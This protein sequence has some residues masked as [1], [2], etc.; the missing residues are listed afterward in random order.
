MRNSWLKNY[1]EDEK[2]AS[3]VPWNPSKEAIKEAIKE[4]KELIRDGKT[5]SAI[6]RIRK[7]I[8]C[9]LREVKEIVNTLKGEVNEEGSMRHSPP[10]AVHNQVDEYKVSCID[11]VGIE[12]LF[13]VGCVYVAMRHSELDMIYVVDR[14]GDTQECFAERFEKV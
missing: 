7:G 9:G 13:E 3:P 1:L 12:H 10:G 11:S 6:R 5:G 2:N 4:A 8:G 14:K